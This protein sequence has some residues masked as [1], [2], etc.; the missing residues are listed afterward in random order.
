MCVH[1]IFSNTPFRV[2]ERSGSRSQINCN[3]IGFDRIV[4]ILQLA[5][6]DCCFDILLYIHKHL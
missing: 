2:L 6:A 4:K 5:V 3:G 1:L